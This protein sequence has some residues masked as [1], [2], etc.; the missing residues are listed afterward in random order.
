MARLVLL[1]ADVVIRAFELG[2]WDKLTAK[3][4]VVLARTVL[5][6]EVRDYRDPATG[7]QVLIDLKPYL[8]TGVSRSWMPT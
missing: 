2:I 5:D 6:R 7:R 4:E 3:R 1:D 8:T